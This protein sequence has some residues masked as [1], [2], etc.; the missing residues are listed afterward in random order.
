MQKN[1]FVIKR[2]RTKEE[3]DISKIEKTIKAVVNNMD[4]RVLAG[5]VAEKV[6]NNGEASVKIERIQDFIEEE[7]IKR[8]YINEARNFISYREKRKNVRLIK[9]LSKQDLVGEYLGRNQWEE[10]ENANTSFC[11]QGLNSHIFTNITKKYWLETI[12][13]QEIRD[14]H[15]QRYIHIHDLSTLSTYCQGLDL[16]DLLF[17]GIPSINGHVGAAPTKHFGAALG[18]IVNF[19]F[20]IQA[21][22]AGAVALSNFDTLLAPF[23]ANDNIKYKDVLQEI[24][25]FVFQM[26]VPSR[27]GGQSPFSNISLDIE[28]PKSMLKQPVIIGG[29]LDDK[30]VYGDF[31]RAVDMINKAFCQVMLEGDVSGRPFTFPIPTYA[32]QDNFDW[33]NKR[34]NPV[35]ELAGKF[36]QPY[37]SNFLGSDLDPEDQKSLCCRLKIDKTKLQYK[38][39]GL[40]GAGALTGSI[41]VVTL[42]LAKINSEFSEYT[43]GEVLRVA[44]ESLEIKRK[45]IEELTGSGLYPYSKFFLRNIKG[46][47]GKF[48]SNHFSTIGVI[49]GHEACFHKGFKGIESKR[50]RE[51][52]CSYLDQINDYLEK[53]QENSNTMW[54]LEATPAESTAYSLA[55]EDGL[56]HQ[57][58]TN[59]TSLPANSMMNLK[60]AMEHQE[61]LLKKYTGGS[62]FHCYIGHAITGDMAKALVKTACEN[63]KIPYISVAPTFSICPKH[64]VAQEGR[65]KCRICGAKMEVYK[66]ITGYIRAVS[67]FNPG[68]RLEHD[69][70]KLYT[71]WEENN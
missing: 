45:K 17:S 65:E 68:K 3:F 29:K 41:G 14:L 54:N 61:P 25:S 39:G 69:E 21:E 57:Y 50:G 13:T 42:N 9:Q 30:K 38:G 66:K 28:V 19:L 46:K 51:W 67:A 37:F 7:L 16:K 58:Y 53:L 12:Y 26:N 1:K 59:S 60:D 23:V 49:G 55:Q 44:V 64:G 52:M 22:T 5:I 8:N 15:N 36:G 40:F 32:I 33:N 71:I 27:V 2:D 31:Q 20:L 18:Q 56:N 34:N 10:K 43:I 63:T 62:V 24:Q 48:W 4:A 35:F 47:T 11:L 6:Y 70:R